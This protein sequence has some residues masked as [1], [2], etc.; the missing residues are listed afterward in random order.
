MWSTILKEW[1]I[2][3]KFCFKLWKTSLEMNE[4]LKAAFGYNT[5]G[6]T[7][8]SEWFSRFRHGDTSVEDSFKLSLHRSHRQK[9]GESFQNCQ[10]TLMKYHFRHCWQVRPLIWKMAVNSNGGLEHALDL[11]KVCASISHQWA[12]AS[13]CVCLPG[14]VGWSQIWPKVSL[15]R[16]NRRQTLVVL[17]QPTNSSL[18]GKAHLLHTQRKWDKSHQT[19]GACLWSFLTVKALFIRDLVLLAVTTGKFCNV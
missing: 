18:S 15:E 12:E 10:Q 1:Y 19:S 6:R 5:T 8:M 4:M 14:T 7:Q 3:I 9:H 11:H 2:C 16:H 13:V 17:L